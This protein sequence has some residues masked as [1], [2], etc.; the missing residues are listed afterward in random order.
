M[1][2][3]FLADTNDFQFE[4]EE[5]DI[6]LVIFDDVTLEDNETVV[7][8]FTPETPALISS[9][10]DVG[11]Y[12]RDTAIVN[13]IDDDRKPCIHYIIIAMPSYIPKLSYVRPVLYRGFFQN[14][15]F[16]CIILCQVPVALYYI[17]SGNI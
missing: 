9:V 15:E 17:Y 12:I 4:S 1:S 8:R 2:A 10:E 13:I 14:T 6:H 16:F 3:F 5:M 7:L 11:Q